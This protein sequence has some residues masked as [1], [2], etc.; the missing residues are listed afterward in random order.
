[1]GMRTPD[2]RGLFTGHFHY[3]RCGKIQI[4]LIETFS[5]AFFKAKN[6]IYQTIF[7]FRTIDGELK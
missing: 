5:W 2:N 6:G 3:T 1:M 7:T 4:S